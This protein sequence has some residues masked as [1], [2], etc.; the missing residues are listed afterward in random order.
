VIVHMPPSND[1]LVGVESEDMK[2]EP[3]KAPSDRLTDGGDPVP[4]LPADA[5]PDLRHGFFR[6]NERINRFAGCGNGGPF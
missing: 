4:R 2:S 6:E 3:G 1:R 5:D